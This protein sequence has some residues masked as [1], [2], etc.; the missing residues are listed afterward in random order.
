MYDKS[1]LMNTNSDGSVCLYGTPSKVALVENQFQWNCLGTGQGAM[2]NCTAVYSPFNC[3]GH[4]NGTLFS[5]PLTLLSSLR[6]STRRLS[7]KTSFSGIVEN[8]Q[9]LWY[10]F[11]FDVQGTQMIDFLPRSY[12][13]FLASVST[14]FH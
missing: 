7:W 12:S 11:P 9:V 4:S 3:S 8:R 14:V 10:L 2:V 13:I 5:L 6:V 1:L